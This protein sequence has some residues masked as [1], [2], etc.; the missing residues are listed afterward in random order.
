MADLARQ[1]TL[2]AAAAMLSAS[3]NAGHDKS[4]MQSI[5]LRCVKCDYLGLIRCLFEQCSAALWFAGEKAPT[6]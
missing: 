5:M 4:V 6:E 1:C 3:C 2:A